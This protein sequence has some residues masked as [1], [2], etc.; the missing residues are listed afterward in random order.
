MTAEFEAELLCG[1]LSTAPATTA[2]AAVG[3]N[4]EKGQPNA[5]GPILKKQSQN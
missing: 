3:K 2:I 5:A 1:P 4:H